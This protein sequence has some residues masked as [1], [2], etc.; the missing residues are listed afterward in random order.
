MRGGGPLTGAAEGRGPHERKPFLRAGPPDIG[1]PRGGG[2]LR[3]APLKAKQVI[4]KIKSGCS[5]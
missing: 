4:L 2:S 1:P 3:G 5:N